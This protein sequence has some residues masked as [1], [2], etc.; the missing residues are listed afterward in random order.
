MRAGIAA[1]SERPPRLDL[2]RGAFAG[3]CSFVEFFD[4]ESAEKV[5]L[6]VTRSRLSNNED[7]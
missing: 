1:P 2:I 3:A 5:K 7:D 4:K 6:T